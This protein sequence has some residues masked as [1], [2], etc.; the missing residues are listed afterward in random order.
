MIRQ[1]LTITGV[2]QGVGFRP[3]VYG[4]A[5]DHALTGFV[6]ND[7]GGVFV[8]VEGPEA[9]VEAFRAGLVNHPPPLAH[10]ESVTVEALAPNGDSEFRIVH[11]E[12]QATRNTLIS[13]D[14]CICDDCLREIFDPANRRYHYPFTNCTHCG[15]RFTII[16]DI[17]YD[18][19]LTTMSAFPMCPDCQCEY[20]D[21]RDRRF[22]AQPNACPV[23]GPRV[24]GEVSDQY[25]VGSIQYSVFSRE[26]SVGG[27]QEGEEIRNTEYAIR[28]TQLL[29][30]DGKIV[31]IKGLGGFHLACDAT[32]DDAVQTLRERKGRVDKPFAVMSPDLDTVRKFAHVSEEE[33]TLLTSRERPILLLRKK[34]SEAAEVHLS[35]L[36]APG[37]QYVGV[38]LPYTPLHYLLFADLHLPFVVGT[39]VPG[40]E[41]PTTNLSPN[42]IFPA[43]VMTSANYSD[44]P[45]V[46]DNDEARERLAPLADAFLFHNR[47]IHARCDDSVIRLLPHSPFTIPNSQFPIL[48]PL[49]RSRGY[50][51]FPVKLPVNLPPTLGVGGELKATF[52]LAKDE[53]AYMS[54]HIGDMENLETLHAFEAAAAHFEGIFRT[55][56][57][58]IACDLHPGYL[59]TRWALE[60]PRGIPVVQ[61]QHH[62]AHIAS[63]MAEGYFRAE[64]RLI[65]DAPV[66]GFSFDGTGYGT[67]GA[68][69]GGEVLVADYRGFERAA[70]L[71]YVPLAGGDLA[72]K[73]PYRMALAHLHA[74]GVAWEEDL[75]CVAACPLTERKVLL[76]QLETGFNTVPTSSMGRLFDAVAALAGIR[77]TVTYEGQAAIEMEALVA[78][79]EGARYTFE[80][81]DSSFDA[82]PVMRAVVEDVRRGVPAHVIAGKFHHAVAG[83]M[84]GISIRLRQQFSI[85]QV[86]LSGG[87]FQNATLLALSAAQLQANG[88]EVLFHKLVPPND[89]GLALGQVMVGALKVEG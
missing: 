81:N 67:D 11:S 23:C 9:A 15:P 12:A 45:I 80:L 53:Y 6:G 66:I 32:R 47:D 74:A 68:I 85:N 49:R 89:G 25:S 64:H 39:S 44:E 76:H 86:A 55:T 28:N 41:A 71:K 84:V 69:W 40:A 24:W 7:S 26:Y 37:N 20:E 75:P 79:A 62:H 58:L 82:A 63:V 56:P 35:E 73:R 46:K 70:H 5:L 48:L 1:R 59:S 4:L 29:L 13:P 77:Q 36:V 8:E 21:P 14:I 16:R 33:A 34:A 22:H 60:N 42:F 27:G 72:V 61:V 78:A 88:F 3:F 30:Q 54:Q 51:P 57:E 19:P 17:P 83:L 38:M 43:L 87:V 52:C 50:A 18:R 65:G 31:A 10:I 2:V